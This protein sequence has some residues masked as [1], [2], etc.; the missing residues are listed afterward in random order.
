MTVSL[1][2]L[3][4]L[5]FSIFLRMHALDHV[6]TA[7]TLAAL[8]C[9]SKV[10]LYSWITVFWFFLK[11]LLLSFIFGKSLCWGHM[12]SCLITAYISYG[13]F[14]VPRC[15]TTHMVMSEYTL[16]TKWTMSICNII[17]F[18]NIICYSSIFYST[19]LCLPEVI[20]HFSLFQIIV[21]NIG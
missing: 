20:S 3:Y 21:E 10:T 14:V 15:V 11:L 18:S 8:I 6:C 2:W 7:P 13:L 19:C 1:F 5:G 4:L 9:S 16:A 12:L 17:S